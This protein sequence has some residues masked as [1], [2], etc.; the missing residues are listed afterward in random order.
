MGSLPLG[1]EEVFYLRVLLLVVVVVEFYLV[2][3]L[4]LASQP[5]LARLEVSELVA[6]ELTLLAVV[7]LLDLELYLFGQLSGLLFS[8]GQ[9]SAL[10]SFSLA[11]LKLFVPS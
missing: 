5:A 8:I 2:R 1:V 4:E 6:L 7:L 9:L 10:L 11:S 3:L